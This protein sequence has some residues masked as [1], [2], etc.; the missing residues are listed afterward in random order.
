MDG[1]QKERRTMLNI[2]GGVIEAQ[3]FD[4]GERLIYLHG[5]HPRLR[6][7]FSNCAIWRAGETRIPA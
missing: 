6:D 1:G 4:K 5:G 3:A 2:G 7:R